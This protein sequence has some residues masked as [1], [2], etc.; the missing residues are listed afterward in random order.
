MRALIIA[1]VLSLVV[2]GGAFAGEGVYWKYEEVL[3]KE[4]ECKGALSQGT[5]FRPFQHYTYTKYYEGSIFVF[6]DWDLGDP[7][8]ACFKYELILSVDEEHPH[9]H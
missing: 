5:L 2:S 9:E 7:H 3:V 6:M 8:L 4:E 1:M